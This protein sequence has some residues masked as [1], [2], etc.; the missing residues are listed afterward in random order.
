EQILFAREVVIETA[1]GHPGP[2]GHLGHARPVVAVG[3]EEFDRRAE[4]PVTNAGLGRHPA[5]A[6]AYSR[7]SSR[8]TDRKCT[9]SGPSARR[10]V[11]S[12]AQ[13]SARGKSPETPPAPCAWI[14]RSS[15]L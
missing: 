1:F 15:T 11:R 8:A 13:P 3:G 4:H 14:A 5:A 6:F 2:L 7:S 10:R 9:S 12:C